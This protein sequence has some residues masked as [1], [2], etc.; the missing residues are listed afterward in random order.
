MPSGPSAGLSPDL[1]VR[2]HEII[3]RQRLRQSSLLPGRAPGGHEWLE[4]VMIR[5][6]SD[7]F[8]R[9]FKIAM[10]LPEALNDGEH[11]LLTRGIVDL[12]RMELTWEER[13]RF[14]YPSPGLYALGRRMQMTLWR[15]GGQIM[16]TALVPAILLSLIVG[17][18]SFGA[19][20]VVSPDLGEN[21]ALYLWLWSNI[22]FRVSDMSSSLSQTAIW[23]WHINIQASVFWCWGAACS[24]SPTHRIGR[25]HF[26]VVL[27]QC[28]LA[29]IL[30]CLLLFCCLSVPPYP[31]LKC[32]LRMTGVLCLT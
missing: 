25:L 29:S 1:T 3:C 32:L 14:P 9:A 4:V 18:S 22:G 17:C 5:N 19:K 20:P 15:S 24:R 6:D 23:Q 26:G 8:W 27:P 2:N 13:Y 12:G 10:P 11:L 31:G 16:T 28:I 7:R 30:N 21:L